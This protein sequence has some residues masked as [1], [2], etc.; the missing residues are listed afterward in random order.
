MRPSAAT[1]A[2]LSK[3]L[4]SSHNPP[5]FPTQSQILDTLPA[6]RRVIASGNIFDSPSPSAPPVGVFDL[7]ASVTSVAGATERR[8][9][10][11]DLAF[12][13]AAVPLKAPAIAQA[14]MNKTANFAN[15][16][17]A[18][19]NDINLSGVVTF[20]SGGPTVADP[21]T[22]AVVGGTGAFIGARGQCTI[23][24]DPAT[25]VYKYVITLL[26]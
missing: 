19:T 15:V 13:Q 10:F 11:I 25:A 1:H 22:L 9:M 4:S 18:P 5:L 6:G 24:F 23:Y 26:K 8:F 17:T 12:S 2:H 20:P 16:A 3:N 14:T 7:A 21:I